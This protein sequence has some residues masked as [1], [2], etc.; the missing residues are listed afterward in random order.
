MSL[1]IPKQYEQRHPGND[2]F[3][4]YGCPCSVSL[5]SVPVHTK[6][7]WLS[8]LI[9]FIH[10]YNHTYIHSFIH[11][12]IHTIIHTYIHN[13]YTTHTNLR[14]RLRLRII[15]RKR[16]WSR[17]KLIVILTLT[18][19]LTLTYL[20]NVIFFAFFSI[21]MAIEICLGNLFYDIL[22]K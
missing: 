12:Y 13:T 1:F 7:P 20:S 17:F 8:A 22:K 21:P 10:T 19:L 2:V 9:T 3:Q 18:L 15:L 6:C 11:T 4:F 14:L 5:F 16:L